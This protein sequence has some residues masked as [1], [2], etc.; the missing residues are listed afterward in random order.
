MLYGYCIT[1]TIFW[2][3]L[4]VFLLLKSHDISFVH[5]VV[6]PTCKEYWPKV[7]VVVAVRNEEAEV[8]NALRSLC[9][10]NYHHYTICVVNDRS[11]DHTA[12]ILER[13]QQEH[14]AIHIITVTHLPAGWLGKNHALYTGYRNS[15]SEWLLFT[16]ADVVFKPLALQKAMTYVKAKKLDHLTVLPEITSPSQLFICVMNT[17]SIM[18]EI[19]LRPW[20]ASNPVSSASIGVGAFNLVKREAY[21]KA[22]THKAISLRPDDDLKLGERIKKSGHRQEAMYGQSEISLNW[23]A[24]LYEFINGLMKNSFAVANYKWY[25]AA[26]MALASI[27]IFVLPVPVAVSMGGWGWV[28]AAIMISFQ[29]ILLS[30]KRGIHGRWWHGI[31]IPFAGL[32]MTYIVMKAAYITL[33]QGGI[34]WRGSFYSLK[35]LRSQQKV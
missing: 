16:D 2:V 4:S 11:T 25:L 9:K 30:C 28:L 32:V 34:Y 10:L 35:E 3:L 26:A 19:K 14:P 15:D 8:E 22:G 21:E 13:I 7:T 18:L 31:A 24:G 29:V 33:K 5:S 20:A 27:L 1:I 12:T 6:L 23:Y 17:F